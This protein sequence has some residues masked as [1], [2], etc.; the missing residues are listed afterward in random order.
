MKLGIIFIT[1]TVFLF[2]CENTV[3]SQYLYTVRR[4]IDG[5]TIE[6]SNGQRVRF[7][8]VDAPEI[9]QP[10]ANEATL[11][12]RGKIE[13]RTIWL[14][15][16][17]NDMDVHGRLRRYVWLKRPANPQDEGYIRQ[18]ML[19]ALLLSNGLARTMIIGNPRN[20]ELFLQIENEVRN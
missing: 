17:G 16:D 3:E 13:N 11:F 7:I 10:G 12:V 18:Y 15:S 4:V 20:A 1:V 14:E 5:D 9:G 6:L 19:N 8:G 2:G